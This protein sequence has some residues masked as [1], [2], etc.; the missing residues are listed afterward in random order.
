MV[1]RYF[2]AFGT[3]CINSSAWASLLSHRSGATRITSKADQ[4]RRSLVIAGLIP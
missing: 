3:L 1:A 2:H 4:Q